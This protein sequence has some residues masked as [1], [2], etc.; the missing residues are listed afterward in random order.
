M[1]L[2]QS[3]AA[4]R[5]GGKDGVQIAKDREDGEGKCGEETHPVGLGFLFVSH[6]LDNVKD[7]EKRGELIRPSP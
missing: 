5:S 7:L 2:V 1:R 6:V 3:R 4:I